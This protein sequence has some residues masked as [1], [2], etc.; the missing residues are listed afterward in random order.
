MRC[1]YNFTISKIEIVAMRKI[2]TTPSRNQRE[3]LMIFFFCLMYF[4]IEVNA[5]TLIRE[6]SGSR[7]MTTS[8]FEVK[9][10]WIL[11]WRINSNYRENMGL[12]IS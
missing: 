12:E 9:A 4:S 8:E 7:S 3:S 10:P 1:L 11:D 5:E 2:K 6:F